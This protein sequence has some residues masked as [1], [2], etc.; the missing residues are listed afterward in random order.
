MAKNL[1]GG[2]ELMI[3]SAIVRRADRRDQIGRIHCR[4][5]LIPNGVFLVLK[6]R[7]SSRE[8]RGNHNQ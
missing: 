5:W 6:V 8:E 2:S 3:R 7:G 4:S 1:H